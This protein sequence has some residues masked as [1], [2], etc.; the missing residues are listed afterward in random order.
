MSLQAKSGNLD[1]TARMILGGTGVD[2]IRTPYQA[3]NCNAYAE[4]FVL[5]IKSSAYGG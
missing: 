2:V 5:S 1:G 4:R 3:P